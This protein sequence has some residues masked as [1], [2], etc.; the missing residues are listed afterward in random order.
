MTLT[1]VKALT[2]TSTPAL[3]NSSVSLPGDH[4]KHKENHLGD[5]PKSVALRGCLLWFANTTP[6]AILQYHMESDKK[7]TCTRSQGSPVLIDADLAILVAR[8]CRNLSLRHQ[9]L[10]RLDM[11]TL[12]VCMLEKNSSLKN[13]LHFQ[14]HVFGFLT[15]NKTL[16]C[17]ADC[18]NDNGNSN[19]A[20]ILL[21]L[22]ESFL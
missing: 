21:V 10:S 20:M 15:S 11:M 7:S 1:P 17:L 3:L 22:L 6:V 2:K 14:L 13:S 4:H 8:P 18:P 12:F 9:H 5:P 19:K 16:I